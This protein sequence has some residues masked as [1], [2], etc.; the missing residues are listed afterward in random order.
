MITHIHDGPV[1]F[2]DPRPRCMKIY[3]NLHTVIDDLPE[4]IVWVK[5]WEG[6]FW[7]QGI[8]I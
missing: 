4:M 5:R 2:P 6:S 1:R 8:Q 3:T 7:V